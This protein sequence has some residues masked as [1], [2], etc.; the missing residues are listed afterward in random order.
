[1]NIGR[2]LGLNI[3]DPIMKDFV[4]NLYRI[5]ALAESSPGFVWRL[6][7]ESN[8][9]TGFS[10]F[11]DDRMIMNM[12]VWEDIETLENFTYRTVHTD[13]LK[14][15]K[16]WFEKLGKTYIAL[17]WVKKGHT[18]TIEEAIE[19]LEYLQEYGPTDQVFNFRKKF[20]KPE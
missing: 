3:D 11:E 20:P 6:K 8:N 2:M 1:M 15:K 12:S 17:W 7:D 14:R 19:K 4:D 18:P 13:F 10:P 5:N 16:E 9:A